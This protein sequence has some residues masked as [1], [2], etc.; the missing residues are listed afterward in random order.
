MTS[1]SVPAVPVAQPRQ[2]S[3]MVAGFM[4]NYT[5]ARHPVNSYKAAVAIAWRQ[6]TDAAP[7]SGP[8]SLAVDFVLP[9]PKSRTRKSNRD[10][11]IH[12]HAKPDL[13]NLLKSTKDALTG[14]AWG[15]DAQVCQVR[16]YKTWASTTEQPHVTITV[17][18][19][20]PL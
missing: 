20:E 4:R 12:H 1:I 3:A 14:L 19:V 16:A 15:D 17:L 18:P 13:D 10:K 5:P 2:R 7:L 9:R 8:V 11:R 6:Q